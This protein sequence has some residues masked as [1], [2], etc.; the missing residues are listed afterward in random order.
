MKQKNLIIGGVAAIVALVAIGGV[1][2][3]A[4]A[5]ENGTTNNSV[6][7]HFGRQMNGQG[8]GQRGERGLLSQ[9]ELDAKKAAIDAAIKAGDYT[10]WVTA[11][12]S[13]CPM[14]GKIN[15]GNFS[16]Y[17]QAYNLR[18]QARLLMEGLGVTQGE[19]GFG[20]MGGRGRFAK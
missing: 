16:T 19:G 11:V 20:M 13:D 2:L 8:M 18:E 4:F 3:S 14:L 7:S 10:A 6:R 9:E 5:A 17:V 1:A 12:G 15:A